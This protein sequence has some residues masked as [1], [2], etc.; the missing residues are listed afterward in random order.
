MSE[1]FAFIREPEGEALKRLSP[2]AAKVFIAIRFG[3][4]EDEPFE[5]GVRDLDDWL[6]SK[7]QAAR[8][9]T[10]LVA[11]GLLETLRPASFGAKRVRRRLRIAHRKQ[12][13]QSQNRD[14]AD[15]RSRK[16]ATVIP[17]Q[18]RK[19]DYE[20]PPQSQ[21]RDIPKE[22]PSASPSEAKAE[23]GGSSQAL[24]EQRQGVKI[25]AERLGM[26][27]WALT[28]ASG[29]PKEANEFASALIRG[30]LSLGEARA[31]L[32]ARKE[33][34]GTKAGGDGEPE[35]RPPAHPAESAPVIFTV[36]A[37]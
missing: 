31:R 24:S 5:L 28:C 33:G 22:P 27:A 16:G 30:D 2:L 36:K 17:L 4:R 35:S 11:A 19:R 1:R 13:E 7:D 21:K 32:T 14:G 12:P 6:I 8:A 20:T 23:G 34:L 15:A 29:G 3:R 37:A 10:E 25:A 26:T 18:S 9:L